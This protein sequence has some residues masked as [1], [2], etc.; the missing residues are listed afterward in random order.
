MKGEETTRRHRRLY[1][2]NIKMDLNDTMCAG[3]D[4][5]HLAQ[6]RDHWLALANMAVNLR[7]PYKAGHQ[8]LSDAA[9]GVS[10]LFVSD[11]LCP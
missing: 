9:H 8:L 6:D 4:R 5:S 1:E 2:D 7:V 10:C 11:N 3:V